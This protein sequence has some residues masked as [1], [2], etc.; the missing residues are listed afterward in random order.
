MRK[1]DPRAAALGGVDELNAS[2]GLCLVEANRITH[3]RIRE[4]L[5]AVQPNLLA[6][7]SILA[8]AGSSAEPPVKFGPE[9]VGKMEGDIDA[10]WGN[11]PELKRFI[12]PGGSE[13]AARL[14]LARTICRR[15]ERDVTAMLAALPQPPTAGTSAPHP[16]AQA[17]IADL[18]AYLNRLSDFLFALA[19]LANRD[20][21]ENDLIWTP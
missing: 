21:G 6:I 14:H 9:A 7:G 16:A 11:L 17:T 4:A 18:K 3:V 1:D 10:I 5:E 8:A 19:R 12:L 13:L 20:S 15:A 2:I